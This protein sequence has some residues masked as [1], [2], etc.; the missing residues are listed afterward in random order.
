MSRLS[1]LKTVGSWAVILV[2]LFGAGIALASLTVFRAKIDL[3]TPNRHQLISIPYQSPYRN[4]DE[5]LESI[6]GGAN[7]AYLTRVTATATP[8]YYFWTGSGGND[9]PK[10]FPL[11]PGEGYALLIGGG[12][13]P[14]T[15]M[16]AGAHVEDV[17]IPVDGL[18][19]DALHWVSIPYHTTLEDVS[20]L[21]DLFDPNNVDSICK[22]KDV[23]PPTYDCYY[24][25]PNDPDYKLKLGE[26][27]EITASSTADGETVAI[28]HM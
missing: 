26:A 25:D 13:P 24:G 14:S 12:T 11:R 1:R 21:Y 8:A 17:E 2:V 3:F 19:A 10:N 6:K 4:A 5:L 15:A 20:D 16:L 23:S 9:T 22:W 7:S 27:Y 28:P 18:V